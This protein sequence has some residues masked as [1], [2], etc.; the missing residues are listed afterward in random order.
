MGTHKQD[1]NLSASR[2]R[3]HE[4][5]NPSANVDFVSAPSEQGK[6]TVEAALHNH[7]HSLLARDQLAIRSQIKT[8]DVYLEQESSHERSIKLDTSL[9]LY[10]LINKSSKSINLFQYEPSI[11]EGK[12]ERI[13]PLDDI[14]KIDYFYS[15]LSCRI[16]LNVRSKIGRQGWVWVEFFSVKDCS[17]F[18][19]LFRSLK[20]DIRFESRK[21][22]V[23]SLGMTIEI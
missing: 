19:Q 2:L 11:N 3:E 18:S 10:I 12:E 20:P 9:P 8:F 16:I 5:K 6:P 15:Q 4:K 17:E 23:L 22:S 21:E 7:E 13:V 14:F 1:S